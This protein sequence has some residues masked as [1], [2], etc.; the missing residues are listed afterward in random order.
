MVFYNRSIRGGAGDTGD[1]YITRFNFIKKVYRARKYP[2]KPDNEGK[3]PLQNNKPPPQILQI[4]EN[5]AKYDLYTVTMN[6]KGKL[7]KLCTICNAVNVNGAFT[8]T[9]ENYFGNIRR[10]KAT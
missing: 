7:Y 2:D 8:E 4:P 10:I 5:I 9:L 1:S 3:K 6:Q